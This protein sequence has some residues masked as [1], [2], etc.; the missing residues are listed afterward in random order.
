MNEFSRHNRISSLRARTSEWRGA[1]GA[2]RRLA[3]L[4]LVLVVASG[5]LVTLLT[6][7]VYEA[8]MKILV[9]PG[10]PGGAIPAAV[11]D[12]EFNTEAAILGSREVLG[13][14]APR[15]QIVPLRDSRVIRVAVRDRNP[16]QAARDLNA[17]FQ[18]YVAQRQQLNPQAST[19][20]ALRTQA[21]DFQRR[22]A[23]ATAALSRFDAES[24]LSSVGLQQELLLRQF[25][26]LQSQ[27]NAARTEQQALRERLS[28]LRTQLAAQ[29]ER[30]E[31][32]S[33]TKYVQTLDKLKGELA[34]LE[35][36]RTQLLQK[37]QPEHRLIRDLELRIAQARE[38]IT[39]EEQNPPRERS[40]ALNETHRRL[41]GEL[42]DAE[43]ALAATTSREQQLGELARRYQQRLTALDQQGYRKNDLERER[44]LNEEA[45][46][47][48]QRRAQEA[49]L[50]RTLRQGERV[51]VSLLEA[52]AV[53]SAPVSP[54]WAIRLPALFLSGL[55][56]ALTGVW[57]AELCRPRIRSGEGVSHRLKLPV[58]ARIPGTRRA[59]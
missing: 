45:W 44:A 34:S 33:V 51:R 19:L 23:E 14:A 13:A 26:D 17:L 7:P 24:G 20:A 36:Q 48:Y 57:L 21:A 22:L 32:S 53:S 1:F 52:V 6:P 15:V 10:Q 16:E 47:L 2:R 38:M 46:L 42:L 5:T 18:Q 49:E 37:Y 55:L 59:A 8:S 35:M 31:T 30:I 54:R 28:A 29:P 25:Y 3:F 9:A 27:A 39:R 50:S 40:V 56:L 4:L 43:A 11:S 12:E 58:L 41:T